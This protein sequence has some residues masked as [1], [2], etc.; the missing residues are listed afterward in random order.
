MALFDESF[1]PRLFMQGI[2]QKKYDALPDVVTVYHGVSKDTEGYEIPNIFYWTT[3]MEQLVPTE[4]FRA[5]ESDEG[6]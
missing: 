3:E 1:A 5:H 2:E 4:D 6:I